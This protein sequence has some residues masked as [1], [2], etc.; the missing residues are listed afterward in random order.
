MLLTELNRD[1]VAPAVPGHQRHGPRR[2]VDD[3]LRLARARGGAAL[4]P[5]GH[6]PAD[7]PQLHPPGRRG[8][9]P[10]R[11]LA[12]RRRSAPRADPASPRRVRRPDDQPADLAGAAPGR[13]R[14]H[15]AGGAGAVGHRPD[16]AL[17]RGRLGPAPSHALPG[18]RPG[19]LRRRRRH[20]RR[21]L[22]PLRHPAERGAGVDP[23]RVADPRADARRR[24][25]RPGQEGH[26][27]A[28]GPH[29]RV[30][31]GAHPPLQDLHRG[32]QGARGRGLRGRREPARRAGL[33]HRLRRI[34]QAVPHAHP[35]PELREPPDAAPHD[36]RRPGRRRRGRHLVGRP[37]PG[38]VDEVRSRW[39]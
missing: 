31:G 1:R 33:L 25:P 7:E 27:A 22:R 29:R 12:R 35:R 20:L 30:D 21:L 10:A 14:H 37:R 13:R 2:R 11:R 8:R 6:R 34:G 19:R 26:A 36:A 39:T 3:A 5:E 9:R 17:H 16:P 15:A 23:D 32:L 4:L 28:A 38:E 18:L 24:L